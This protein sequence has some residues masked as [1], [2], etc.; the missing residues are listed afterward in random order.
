M[1][2]FDSVSSKM[3]DD[4]AV[5]ALKYLSDCLEHYYGPKVLIFL[6]EYDT[7]RQEAYVYGYWEEL[8]GFIRQMFNLA[9]KTNPGMERA[10]MTGITRVSRE[11]IF[12][13]LNNLTVVTTTSEKYCTCFGFTEGRGVPGAGPDGNVGAQDGCEAMVRWIHLWQPAGI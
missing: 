11:S 2:F 6:D 9:F 10:I 13:D 12:S 4:V 7:P 3:S 1:E 8:A 5:L